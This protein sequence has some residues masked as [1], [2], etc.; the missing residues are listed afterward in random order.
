MRKP[1]PMRP[2]THKNPRTMT[3]EVIDI[4]LI[5]VALIFSAFFSGIETAFLSTSRLKIELKNAQNDRVGIMLSGFVKRTPRVLST[6]LVG[7]TLSL[8]L[9]GIATGNLLGDLFEQWGWLDS[10]RQPYAMMAL[11]T[12]FATLLLLYVGE[13]FPKAFFRL[14]AEQIMFQPVTTGLLQGFLW[15]FKPLVTLVNACARVFLRSILRIHYKEEELVFSKDDLSLYLQQNLNMTPDDEDQPEI[16][17]E[18]FTNA[19]AFNEVRVREFMVPRTELKAMSIESSIDELH[20]YFIEQGHS[21]ILIY[22][23]SLDEVVGFV[24]HSALFRRPKTIVEVMQPILLVPEMMAANLLLSEF[25]KHRKSI[26]VVV[27]EFGGTEGI[28]TIEDLVE[29]VFGEIEDEHDEPE[30]EELLAKQLD[31][32]T[33][34][35]STRH[36]VKDLNENWDL[37]LP[38]GEGEYSTLAGLI[39]HYLEAIPKIDDVVMIDHFRIVITDAS[40]SKLNIVR[41]EVLPL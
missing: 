9:Y 26:A 12:G 19:M 2:K 36:E 23:D 15:L 38:E 3:I 27:D 5:V 34:L 24:H 20:A 25:S 17:E 4:V 39:I 13:F 32:H 16:D 18:M 10:T 7:N 8:V 28:V 11:Q 22:K 1:R 30:E 40:G 29:V 14:R 33:W 35:F 37:G 31:D 21:R 6:I 41:V